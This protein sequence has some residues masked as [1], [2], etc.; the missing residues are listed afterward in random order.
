M[1]EYSFKPSDLLLPYDQ[2]EILINREMKSLSLGEIEWLGR[3][4]LWDLA[5]SPMDD[6]RRKQIRYGHWLGWWHA[7][8]N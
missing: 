1:N 5:C 8:E 2:W 4:E 6:E 3:W 7:K